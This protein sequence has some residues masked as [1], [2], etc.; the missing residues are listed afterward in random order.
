MEWYL[1]LE[2]LN[3]LNEWDVDLVDVVLVNL[4]GKYQ[5]PSRAPGLLRTESGRVWVNH[6]YLLKQFPFLKIG[7]EALKKR[8]RHLVDIGILEREI[9]Y[10][11]TERGVRKNTCYGLSEAFIEMCEYFKSIQTVHSDKELD[12][13]QKQHKLDFL[14]KEKPKISRMVADDHTVKE[15]ERDGKGRYCKVTDYLTPRYLFTLHQG[16]QLPYN[17]ISSPNPSSKEDT[18]SKFVAPGGDHS[19]DNLDNQAPADAELL[20]GSA[21]PAP[22]TDEFD[23]LF[24]SAKETTSSEIGRGRSDIE[25]IKR[26][27]ASIPDLADRCKMIAHYREMGY[28][29]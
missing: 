1:N 20:N 17:P 2:N 5:D 21:P 28:D 16:N 18:A 10:P 29:V 26:E 25:A 4:V 13:T 7:I 24:G 9:I 23:K 12:E 11:F 15:R 6:P 3:A 8:L 14:L 22:L 19:Q 27:I